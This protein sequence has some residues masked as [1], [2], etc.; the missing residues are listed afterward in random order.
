M[1]HCKEVTLSL[2]SL[3]ILIAKER[4]QVNVA[5]KTAGQSKH[6]SVCVL[7]SFRILNYMTKSP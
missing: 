6:F 3:I 5:F 1:S 4:L 7:G 2:E